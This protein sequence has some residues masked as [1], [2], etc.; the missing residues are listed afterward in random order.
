M[1]AGDPVGASLRVSHLFAQHFQEGR[2]AQ[3]QLENGFKQ[4]EN[5]SVYGAAGS[6]GPEELGMCGQGHLSLWDTQH[7]YCA[8]T[9]F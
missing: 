8:Y 5:V 3:Q 1:L 2:R 6:S 7:T 9:F 4:L